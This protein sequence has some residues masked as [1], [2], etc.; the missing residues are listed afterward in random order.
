[1]RDFGGEIEFVLPSGHVDEPSLIEKE[2][3]VLRWRSQHPDAPAEALPT[4]EESA[5]LL[6]E[7]RERMAGVENEAVQMLSR[8]LRARDTGKSNASRSFLMLMVIMILVGTAAFFVINWLLHL[9]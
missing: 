3:I 1:M 8:A 9:L 4:P 7:I 2:A 5:Q 6:L